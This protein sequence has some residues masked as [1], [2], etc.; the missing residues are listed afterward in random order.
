MNDI[1]TP[2]EGMPWISV[3]DRPLITKDSEGRWECTDDGMKEFIAAV[4]YGLITNPDKTLWWIR[5]CVMEDE[6]GLCVIG[7]D[8]NESAGHTIDD[9]THY[10]HLP[11]P[12]KI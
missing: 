8:D 2:I 3:Q 11:A 12:P 10:F 1:S 4:P 7:D 6:I 9:V 5:L